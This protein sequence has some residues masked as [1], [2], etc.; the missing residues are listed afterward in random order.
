MVP[1]E[2]AEPAEPSGRGPP[3]KTHAV[4][5]RPSARPCPGSQ[6]GGRADAGEAWVA[7]QPAAG[8][9][10]CEVSEEV[11]PAR[12]T[13]RRCNPRLA[14]A[15]SDGAAVRERTMERADA[16]DRCCKCSP[17]ARRIRNGHPTLRSSCF[18][19]RRQRQLP[20]RARNA[21]ARTSMR[22]RL[23]DCL[24]VAQMTL[25]TESPPRVA[26]RPSASGG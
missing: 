20:S 6:A 18:S 25:K 10:P 8:G 19:S 12:G 11:A 22:L 14:V 3:P 9:A 17:R 7:A 1:Q 26:F 16:R 2:A 5:I 13:R 4:H 21:R 15:T 23:Y 24:M